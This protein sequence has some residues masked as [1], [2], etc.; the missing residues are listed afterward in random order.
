MWSDRK[1]ILGL[2]LV[3]TLHVTRAIVASAVTPKSVFPPSPD[4][5]GENVEM[6]L[7]E[8]LKGHEVLFVPA[9]K[10]SCA[11]WD[12][13][14]MAAASLSDKPVVLATYITVES[15]SAGVLWSQPWK[16]PS[17][18]PAWMREHINRGLVLS[19]EGV[20]IDSVSLPV[21]EEE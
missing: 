5:V 9:V 16:S 11:D 10:T 7:P 4:A 20:V 19:S 12:E 6:W 2:G 14:A 3:L 17:Q 21:K 1:F 8:G 13:L 15:G 18:M